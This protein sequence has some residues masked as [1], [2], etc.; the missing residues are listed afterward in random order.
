VS[1]LP[2]AGKEPADARAPSIGVPADN[3][4][5]QWNGGQCSITGCSEGPI[6]AIARA[7]GPRRPPH[8]Q[9]YCASHARERGVQGVDGTLVW[10]AEFLSPPNRNHGAKRGSGPRRP[11][12]VPGKP[13]DA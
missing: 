8:W 6:A 11:E 13:A 1:Q 4:W 7:R 3:G 10:T 2:Q 5:I 9:P 12:D